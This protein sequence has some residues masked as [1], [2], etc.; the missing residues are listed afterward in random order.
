MKRRPPPFAVIVAIAAFILAQLMGAVHA[1]DMGTAG[2]AP[3]K[4][5]AVVVHDD[6]DCCDHGQTA[7]DPSCDNHCQQAFKAPERVQAS[8]VASVVAAGV[9]LP[10]VR[11]SRSVPPASVLPAPHL[12]R[13]TEPPI[14]IRNCCF[15][16]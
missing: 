15:R 6:G 9:A 11:T 16:I 7:P 14:S 13:H 10:A 5:A 1:C 3:A 4:A 8:G 12:A 2:Q